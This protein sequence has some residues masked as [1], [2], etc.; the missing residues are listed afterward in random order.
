MKTSQSGVDL[1]KLFEGLRFDA[2]YDAVGVLTIGYGHTGPDVKINSRVNSPQAEALLKQDLAKF[3]EA[4]ERLVKVPLNQFQ[5]DALV[6]FC[7]NIGINAFN[8]ST[9]LRRLNAKEDPCIVAKEE[10][11]RWNKGDGGKELAGLTRRR[12][13]EVELFCQPAPTARPGLITISANANTYLKKKPVP[14]EALSNDQKA[15]ISQNREIKNCTI[16]ERKNN[17]TYL[18]LGFGLGKWWVFDPHWNGLETEPP[19]NAYAIDKDLCFLRD[20]PYFYQQDNGSE[21]W[22]QC[23][24]STIAMCLRYLDVPGIQDDVD[25]LKIVNKY[26]DTTHREPHFKALSELGVQAKFTLSADE[27]D[28]KNE[29]KKGIPVVAGILHH[30]AY[31]SPVGGGHFVV[32]T[33][34]G[35]DY[36]LVQDPYGSLNLVDGG[37]AKRGAVDGK[38]IKYPFKY[39]NPRFFVGGGANGWCWLGFKRK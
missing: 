33:G 16:L 30:G 38:N 28:V 21:G 11:P 36:W 37:W 35:K 2:Y 22:R 29:I 25:Y 24:T 5:F 20:F 6:S 23:Q 19:I 26:G 18:E 39:F 31:T 34:Y 13:S 27:H 1:I 9:L 8:E 10:L 7:F 4:V 15:R 14:S 32:I 17:H 3:E 12:S